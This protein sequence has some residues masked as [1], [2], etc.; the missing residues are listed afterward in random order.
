MLSALPRSLKLRSIA[1]K[2]SPTGALLGLLLAL[3]AFS[4][5]KVGCWSWSCNEGHSTS[6]AM[7]A[8]AATCLALAAT[9]LALAKRCHPATSASNWNPSP[10]GCHDGQT[11][12]GK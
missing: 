11:V 4:P 2:V 6:L 8:L 12:G 9:S 7:L 3:R 5:T 1:I 10:S